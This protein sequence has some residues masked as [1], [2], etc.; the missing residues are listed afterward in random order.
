MNAQEMYITQA[1]FNITCSLFHAH[2]FLLIIE[3][4]EI[5]T[6]CG[7]FGG[8]ALC[9]TERS[10]SVISRTYS[11]P[12]KHLPFREDTHHFLLTTAL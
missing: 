10:H 3:G 8:A 4:V 2:F 6:C 1:G 5:K 9:H 7:A 12:G 11:Q